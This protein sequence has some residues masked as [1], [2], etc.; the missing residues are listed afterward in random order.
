MN[1]M[2]DKYEILFI[3]D[4]S[5]DSTPQIIKRIMANDKNVKLIT[6][7]INQ[8]FG[9]AISTG[10]ENVTGDVI[11][12]MDADLT[13]DTDMIT[14]FIKE[15]R[16]GYDIV[17]GSRYIENGGMINVPL[18]RVFVSKFAGLLFSFLFNMF[19][20]K[21][22]TSGYRTYSS[23]V[24]KIDI[25]STGFPVQIEILIKMKKLGAKI[26]EIPIILNWRK[27]GYSKFK[28]FSVMMEYL[29]M[30]IYLKIS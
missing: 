5:F 22:K 10:F 1:R 6:H 27:K 15:V 25:T 3:N 30:V 13:H 17:I 28:I 18:W 7:K 20:I 16:N 21:D 12:T 9:A 8:G 26:K 11:I 19:D 29:K 2:E 23:L 24:K 14:N 4:G